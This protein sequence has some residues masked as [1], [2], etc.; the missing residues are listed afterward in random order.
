M[1]IRTGLLSI[2][3]ALLV[4]L[5]AVGASHPGQALRVDW[6][7][8]RPAGQSGGVLLSSAA[9]D[10]GRELSSELGGR[11]IEI[12]GFLLPSDR[13][14]AL[15]YEF[16]LVPM[17][18]ACSHSRQPPPNQ[19]VRVTPEQPFEAEKIYQIVTVKGTLEASFDKAQLFILDGVRVVESGYHIGSAA[20]D[21]GNADALPAAVSSPWKF[22]KQ[23]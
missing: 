12:T 17:A 15:V 1:G 4:A 9:S 19:V 16:M 21:A 18:G 23:P 3:A 6:S 2:A 20:V 7:A 5:P 11:T 22:L 8:L 10:F 14:G 13:E